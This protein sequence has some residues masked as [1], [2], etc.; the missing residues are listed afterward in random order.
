[1]PCGQ[2]QRGVE[3]GSV[4]RL[5]LKLLRRVQL[6]GIERMRLPKHAAMCQ[7]APGASAVRQMRIAGGVMRVENLSV[8]ALPSG[9]KVAS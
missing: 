3:R 4:V 2:Q 8:N 9:E 6:V 7:S 1:M 5:D